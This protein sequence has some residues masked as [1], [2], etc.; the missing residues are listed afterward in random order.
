[1]QCHRLQVNNY[2]MSWTSATAME[3]DDSDLQSSQ[4]SIT[5]DDKMLMIW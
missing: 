3:D 1:M 5:D 2:A 4:G